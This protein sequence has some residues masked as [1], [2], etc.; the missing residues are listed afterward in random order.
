MK[1]PIITLIGQKNSGKST[2]FNKLTCTN[3]ALVAHCPGLT[4]DL[5]YGYLCC[6]FFKSIIVDT[7]GIGECIF[8]HYLDLQYKDNIYHQIILAIKEANIVLFLVDGQI[9][10]TSVDFD[11]INV[12]RKLEKNIFIVI[13]KIDDIN[14]NH[15]LHHGYHDFGIENVFA[16]SAMHGHGINNLL[17]KLSYYI[18]ERMFNNNKK[19]C[20]LVIDQDLIS[21]KYRLRRF[22]SVSSCDIPKNFIILAVVGCSNSGKSTFINKILGKDRM[23]TCNT[24]GTTRDSIYT[25]TIYGGQN[26]V[27]IDTAGIRK[28]KKLNN[29]IAEQISVNETFQVIKDDAHIILFMIDANIGV[30]DKN[31]SALK[32]VMGIG[33]S[34]IIVI[35]KWDSISVVMRS[36]IKNIIY[37][38]INFIE[39]VRIHFISAL[40]G[41]GI[42]NL[43]ESIRVMYTDLMNTRVISTSRFTRIMRIAI[44]KYPPPLLHSNIRI[45]PKYVHV[46]GYSPLVLIIHGSHVSKLSNDYQKYLKNFFYKKLNIKGVI[47]HIQLKDSKNP[48]SNKKFFL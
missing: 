2:L 33:M 29:N 6:K 18:E 11:I 46:G 7:G 28:K 30:S 20:M 3:D 37:K 48:F 39:F 17:K 13:N 35:N 40:Y 47:L 36:V 8:H 42:K 34:L 25:S 27:L 45:Q 41:N 10:V 15:F 1:L 9:K 38:K 16:I 44:A 21:K 32:H 26:Y 12:L 5:Q 22:L 19:N 43:F 31:L 4:R 14:N 23:I 24:P